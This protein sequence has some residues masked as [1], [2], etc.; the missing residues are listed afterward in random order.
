MIASFLCLLSKCFQKLIL[1]KET[2]PSL[3]M[4]NE[5]PYALLIFTQLLPLLASQGEFVFW[6]HLWSELVWNGHY[7]LPWNNH[8]QWPPFSLR[9]TFW[10]SFP[11]H[12]WSNC[13]LSEVF[14]AHPIGQPLIIPTNYA[15]LLI[16]LLSGPGQE[17]GLSAPLA[18]L[19]GD[20]EM[21]LVLSPPLIPQGF[22]Q[23]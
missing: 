3:Y 13:T 15:C 16:G 10:P 21:G 22:G 4:S 12:L 9:R 14:S 2:L 5:D 23:L 18:K 6:W 8:L 11:P 1:L 17:G 19:H 7:E 20:R